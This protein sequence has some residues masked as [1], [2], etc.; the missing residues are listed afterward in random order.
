MQ[1]LI[2]T[3]KPFVNL[4]AGPQFWI[5]KIDGVEYQR[6]LDGKCY[7]ERK[8]HEFIEAVDWVDLHRQMHKKGYKQGLGIFNMI[9]SKTGIKYLR[10]DKF[11]DPEDGRLT[12]ITAS[13]WRGKHEV[14][15]DYDS[16]RVA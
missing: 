12:F 16:P 9:V 13:Q 11:I 5:E 4:L 10:S 8:T 2:T 15:L 1:F 14:P 6:M 3:R 7:D